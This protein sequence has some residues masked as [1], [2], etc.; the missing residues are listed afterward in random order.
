MSTSN[1]GFAGAT[2][3]NGPRTLADPG[4]KPANSQSLGDWVRRDMEY[5]ENQPRPKY[6]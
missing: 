5:K 6:S 3:V 4:G 1:S 2:T